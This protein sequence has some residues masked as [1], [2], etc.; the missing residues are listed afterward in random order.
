MDS[1]LNLGRCLLAGFIGACIVLAVGAAFGQ[2][3]TKT[4]ADEYR[5][6]ANAITGPWASYGGWSQPVRYTNSPGAAAFFTFTIAEK[7]IYTLRWEYPLPSGEVGYYDAATWQVRL[8]ANYSSQDVQ[9][10]TALLVAGDPACLPADYTQAEVILEGPENQR[11]LTVKDLFTERPLEVGAT[12]TVRIQAGT[13]SLGGAYFASVKLVKV[14]TWSGCPEPETPP[15]PDPDP[16]P[17]P[18]GWTPG[19]CAAFNQVVTTTDLDLGEMP[20]FVYGSL[21]RAPSPDVA[22]VLDDGVALNLGEGSNS[23]DLM[24]YPCDTWSFTVNIWTRAPYPAGSTGCVLFSYD[25]HVGRNGFIN[26]TRTADGGGYHLP[27]PRNAFSLL[28]AHPSIQGD[29]PAARRWRER[30][31]KLSLSILNN[32]RLDFR[33]DISR[34]ASATWDNDGEGGGGGSGSVVLNVPDPTAAAAP[35]DTYDADTDGDQVRDSDDADPSDPA[36]GR[37]LWAQWV[38][39]LR[40]LV[41]SWQW[42]F[43]PQ[44]VQGAE[45]HLKWTLPLSQI[46]ASWPDVEWSTKLPD[47]PLKDALETVRVPFRTFLL[48]LLYWWSFGYVLNLFGA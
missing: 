42:D 46:H 6:S 9:R 43:T 38:E 41:P 37:P 18:E 35:T 20:Y 22:L 14:S 7:G 25:V 24:H 44:D 31:S 4:N 32:E 48:A 33:P 12:M 3:Q 10:N 8:N 1:K 5:N 2:S 13:H 34:C 45:D 19:N 29:D 28:T 26:I 36:L 27:F 15:P 47:G 39:P 21:R 40:Q 11:V 23:P 30:L 17:Q 16:N